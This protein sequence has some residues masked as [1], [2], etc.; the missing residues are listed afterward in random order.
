MKELQEKRVPRGKLIVFEG[1][2]GCGKTTQLQHLYQWLADR[3]SGQCPVLMTKEP[4]ATQWGQSIRSLLLNPPFRE[5]LDPY[6]ELL[7]YE[8]DRAQHVQTVLK[9]QLEAGAIILCDRH[10]DSTLAYQGYGRGLDLDTITY[11][12]Q[13]ATQGLTSDLTLWLDVAVPV[14]RRRLVARGQADR[15]EQT[16]EQ[17]DGQFYDRVRQGFAQLS[18]QYPQ[19][20]VR[21]EADAAEEEVAATIQGIVQER[22]GL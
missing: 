1:I 4:G 13:I 11:L 22:L 18:Q 8:A 14:S 20:I 15:M 19:R 21:V 5:P 9:P 3:G 7:L 6:A 12:N 17:T 10:T 2:D 16:D